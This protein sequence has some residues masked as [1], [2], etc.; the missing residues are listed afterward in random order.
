MVRGHD[1]RKPLVIMT[2][3][4]LLRHPEATSSLDDMSGETA[5]EEVL[6]DPE[7]PEGIERV[8]RLIFCSG[9]VYYDLVAHRRE[10][11]I[12]NAAI[13]RIEQLYPYHWDRVRE[14]IGRYPRDKKKLVWCQEEP[15][16]MG[17][18][19]YIAPRLR[20]SAGPGA[21]VRYAGRERAASPAAG[22]KA[23]H[24]RE[25]RKLVERAFSV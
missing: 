3:K 14:I 10:H 23:I 2:P 18:W 9:K 15:L 6:D 7:T 25:Q 8:N 16:N 5:F 12:R 20:K 19:S 13:I 21:H 22:A 24:T 1:F 11:E 17:A 4:S